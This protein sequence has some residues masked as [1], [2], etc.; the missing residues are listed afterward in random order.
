MSAIAPSEHLD[1]IPAVK[2]LPPIATTP[3][4][5][6]VIRRP[7]PRR[8]RSVL[9]AAETEAYAGWVHGALTWFL[10][11]DIPPPIDWLTAIVTAFAP[12]ITDPREYYGHAIRAAVENEDMK[13]LREIAVHAA[14]VNAQMAE[15]AARAAEGAVDAVRDA[16]RLMQTVRIDIRGANLPS[17]AELDELPL[18]LPPRVELS[19]MNRLISQSLFE[20]PAVARESLAAAACAYPL[21]CKGS[22]LLRAGEPAWAWR[23]FETA[24][25]LRDTGTARDA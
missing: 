11:S 18:P 10:A 21:I 23:Y 17:P 9:H 24:E 16:E 5:G 12:R 1:D 14:P 15:I 3:G 20:Q 19:Q 6:P 7:L 22:A 8:D 4:Y 25:Q 13:G 2:Y